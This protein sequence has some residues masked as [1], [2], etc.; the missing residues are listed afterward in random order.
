[1]EETIFEIMRE[2]MA[3]QAILIGLCRSLK[4]AGLGWHVE[5]AFKY[6]DHVARVGAYRL[7]DGKNTAD[8]AGFTEIVERLR[9][10]VLE[11][12]PEYVGKFDPAV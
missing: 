9:L 5:R 1:M 8:L 3:T 6:A 2:T 11:S 7:A 10:T 4:Q 12:D